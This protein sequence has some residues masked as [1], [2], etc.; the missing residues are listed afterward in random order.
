MPHSVLRKEKRLRVLF[1]LIGCALFFAA[2]PPPAAAQ[3]KSWVMAKLPT[4]SR[5]SESIR[6]ATSTQLCST[7]A[8]L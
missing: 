7:P 5:V 2:A 3:F 8:R 6:R 1:C 4:H